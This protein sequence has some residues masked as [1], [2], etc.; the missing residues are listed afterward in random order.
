MTGAVGLAIVAAFALALAASAQDP[1]KDQPKDPKEPPKETVLTDKDNKMKVKVPVGQEVLVKLPA[2]PTTGFT[3]VVAKNDKNV[4]E[5][6]GEPKYEK[7]AGGVGGGG[8]MIFKFKA[9]K[10]G[11]SNLEM[12]YLRTF[13]K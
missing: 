5:Q 13:E 11:D 10:E 2:N 1:N 9:A 6:V 8:T 7:G 3:W 4:L 12:H